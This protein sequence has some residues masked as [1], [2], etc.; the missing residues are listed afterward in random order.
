MHR[1]PVDST[2][3]AELR[4]LEA[5]REQQQAA[6]R[7][8]DPACRFGWLGED[9]EGRPIPCGICR[10]HLH[11]HRC[12]GCLALANSCTNRRLLS[13]RDC[14]PACSHQSAGVNA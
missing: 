13:G 8:H 12:T 11:D 2:D 5:E 3:A 9:R 6:E 10:P 7:Y 4:E 1:I 14:C